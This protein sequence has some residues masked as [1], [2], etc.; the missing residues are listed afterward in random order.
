MPPKDGQELARAATITALARHYR[1]E[2]TAPWRREL[3]EDLPHPQYKMG[4][5]QDLLYRGGKK[6]SLVPPKT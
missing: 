1:A 3:A 5:L 6:E 4:W 2:V